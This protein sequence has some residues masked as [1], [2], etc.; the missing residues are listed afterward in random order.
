MRGKTAAK[1]DQMLAPELET[2]EA[3]RNALAAQQL[4][5]LQQRKVQ[6]LACCQA[7]RLHSS[8]LQHR[9]CS[10]AVWRPGSV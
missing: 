2:Q 4:V 5:R 7:C 1:L 6:V 8:E 10:K 9:C 3:K